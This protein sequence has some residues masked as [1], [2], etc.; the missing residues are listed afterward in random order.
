[1]SERD[2]AVS[3]RHMLDYACEAVALTEAKAR[4]DLEGD[5][6]LQ[7][8]LTRLLEVVGE[9]AARVSAESQARLPAIPWTQ[10]IGMRNRLIHG[11]DVLDWDL[12]WDTVR[13]D[14]PP[15]IIELTRIVECE[16]R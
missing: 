10:I 3:L 2:D 5:R 12:L 6:L 7:L 15:L 13:D 8:A 16:Q 9:A 1:M 14:L 11:Y 4:K